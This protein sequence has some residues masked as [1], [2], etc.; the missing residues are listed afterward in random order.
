MNK[1]M[2][3]L[4]SAYFLMFAPSP[5]SVFGID[6]TTP[7]T[8]KNSTFTETTTISIEP[9]VTAVKADDSDSISQ[10]VRNAFNKDANLSPF[11]NNVTV[12]TEKGV[13]TL[14]GTVQSDKVIT[15]FGTKA[16]SVTGVTQVVNKL[17]VTPAMTR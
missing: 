16:G 9:A 7:M 3:I 1:K 2:F 6:T 11:A 17:V 5:V 14:T 15:D 12:K 8:D 13:V 4:A 10:E